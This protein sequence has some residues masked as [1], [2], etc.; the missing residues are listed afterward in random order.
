MAATLLDA[1]PKPEPPN[2]EAG[3]GAAALLASSLAVFAA[4]KIDNGA[5]FFVSPPDAAAPNADAPDGAPK[6]NVVLGA[7]DALEAPVE[8]N[9]E[10]LEGLNENLSLP[11]SGAAVLG[12]SEVS[13]GFDVA[14]VLPPPNTGADEGPNENFCDELVPEVLVWGATPG[15]EKDGPVVEA[16][17]AVAVGGGATGLGVAL[18]VFLPK[19][20]FSGAV[21][22]GVVEVGAVVL[23]GTP[24]V[25]GGLGCADDDIDAAEGCEPGFANVNG[26]GLLVSM[27]G[28]V[29]AGKALV[30]GGVAV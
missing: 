2:T 14:V 9:A 10:P 30:V 25:D 13:A 20:N 15:N 27:L 18:V 4:P 17:A 29:G 1:P 28:A 5:S 21:A 3:A 12:S 11:G 26:A 24:N 6:L 7:D 22:D 8:P 23:G 16:S 19:S